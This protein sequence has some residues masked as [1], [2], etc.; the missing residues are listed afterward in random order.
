MSSMSSRESASSIIGALDED[1]RHIFTNAIINILAT[2]LAEFTYAQVLDGLPTEGSVRSGFH[3]IHDHPVFT[4]RHKNLCEGFLDK[5]R[6]FTARFDPSELCFDP[7]I[8]VFL[9]E[10]DDGAHKHEAHQTWLDM[11]KREPKGQNPPRHYIPPATIFVH[12]AYRSAERYPRGTAD[13]AGYWA[14]GQIFGGVVWFE[15]GE[16]DSECQ[17][18]WIHGASQ[19]GPRTLYPPTQRQLDSLISFL[20]SR[21]DEDSVCPLPIHGTPENRPRWDPYEAQSRF[22]IFR[23]KNLLSPP[24]Q[25]PGRSCTSVKASDWPEVGDEMIWVQQNQ[26][27]E[28]G[29]LYDV[30][31]M[32]A[33]E[34]GM[35]LITPTSPLYQQH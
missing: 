19:G 30:E 28:W 24:I 12:R 31:V 9:Y 14:E 26:L 22:H 33:A 11:V 32:V 15:R 7:L 35:K 4:L 6:K 25:S 34:E 13:V 18:I 23:D 2:D 27:R 21:P 29:E 1:H 8:A 20:L 10:L 17:G 5:A 16:T 3:F